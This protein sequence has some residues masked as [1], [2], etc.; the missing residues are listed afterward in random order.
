MP[1]CCFFSLSLF[2][3]TLPIPFFPPCSYVAHKQLLQ[4][5]PIIR[6]PVDWFS[7][8][9]PCN[10]WSLVNLTCGWVVRSCMGVVGGELFCC[11]TWMMDVGI[12]IKYAPDAVHIQLFRWDIHPWKSLL[13]RKW[14]LNF[15]FQLGRWLRPVEVA[16]LSQ[17][18]SGPTSSILILDNTF[19]D[20]LMFNI[21]FYLKIYQNIF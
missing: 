8:N 16:C 20:N 7:Q 15:N 17:V 13:R 3:L 9:L 10:K 6:I 12:V 4:T 18:T 2:F 5:Y 19:I 1:S 11:C 14:G 21:Y